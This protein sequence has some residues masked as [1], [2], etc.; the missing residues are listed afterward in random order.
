MVQVKPEGDFLAEPLRILDQRGTN[1][2]KR[3]I[4]QVKLQWKHFG[5]KEATWE[6]EEFMRKAYLTFY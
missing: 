3:A 4:T 5:S 2:W 6:E 1:L